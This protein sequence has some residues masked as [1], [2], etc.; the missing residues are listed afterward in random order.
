MVETYVSLVLISFGVI[1]ALVLLYIVWVVLVE[2]ED[3][4]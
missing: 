2:D 1:A 4:E 3:N